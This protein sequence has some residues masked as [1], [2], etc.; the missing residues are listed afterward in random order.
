MVHQ[1]P[2]VLALFDKMELNS[3]RATEELNF[4]QR[5]AKA[6]IARGEEA[7][8][9]L[10]RELEAWLRVNGHLPEEYKRETHYLSIRDGSL[11]IRR[12]DNDKE[13]VYGTI[14]TLFKE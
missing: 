4:L 11:T 14:E 5:K 2:A 10:W 12:K 13:A 9:V 8:D 7:N 3:Q 1:V 6:V